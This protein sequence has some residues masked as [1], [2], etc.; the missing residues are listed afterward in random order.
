[1][2]EADLDIVDANG[3]LVLQIAGL[4]MG[5][6]ESKNSER[7]RILAERLLTVEWNQQQHPQ[8]AADAAAGAWLLIGD[9]QDGFATRCATPS[10]RTAPPAG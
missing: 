7:D 1:M 3:E 2:I 10:P 6:Q 5:T 9:E 4:R 8:A